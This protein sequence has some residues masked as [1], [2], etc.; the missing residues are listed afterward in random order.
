M[1]SYSEAPIH[2]AALPF[3]LPF[4]AG[5]GVAAWFHAWPLCAGFGALAAFVLWFFRNP[6]RS[7]AEPGDVV[8]S[9][10]DGTVTELERLEDGRLRISIFLSVLFHRIA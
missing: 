4:L 10:A 6:R 7:P 3:A 5:T 9:P 8:V 1:D 2:P